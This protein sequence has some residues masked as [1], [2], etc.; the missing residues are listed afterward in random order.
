[1]IDPR[2]ACFIF[3]LTAA[4]QL[5]HSQKGESV[6]LLHPKGKDKACGT[7]S[8]RLK[9][10]PRLSEDE[11]AC[12]MQ[13]CAFP[14]PRCSLLLMTLRLLKLLSTRQTLQPPPNCIWL[15]TQVCVNEKKKQ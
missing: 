12:N 9:A 7:I 10:I 5:A 4:F 11:I 2:S 13:V 14:L 6:K 15:R 3:H 1:L 8:I